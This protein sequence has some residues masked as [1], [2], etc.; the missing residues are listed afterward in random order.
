MNRGDSGSGSVQVL[1]VLLF[2]SVL[3]VGISFEITRSSRLLEKVEAATALERELD[4]KCRR[5]VDYLQK[6]GDPETDTSDDGVWS[7]IRGLEKNGFSLTM[8][9]VSSRIGRDIHPSL[10]DSVEWPEELYS[11]YGWINTTLNDTD[12]TYP[13]ANTMPLF[14]IYF[15]DEEILEA[16]LSQEYEGE[17]LDD[18]ENKLS[19]IISLRDSFSLTDESLEEALDLEDDKKDYYLSYLGVTTWFWK[20]RAAK[21]N[22]SHTMV[23]ARIP[24]EDD[25]VK[26]LSRKAVYQIIQ[27]LPEKYSVD[28]Q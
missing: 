13:V 2:L 7:Y 11:D 19:R 3:A 5:V 6:N 23:I 22:R 20:I 21:N 26:T 8:E 17:V 4:L 10:F 16:I 28:N 12:Y 14:N 15:T 1:T 25:R 24:V 27:S 9:D 18:R